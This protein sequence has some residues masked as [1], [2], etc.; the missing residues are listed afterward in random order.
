MEARGEGGASRTA[1]HRP[2]VTA[3]QVC[4]RGDDLF[5]PTCYPVSQLDASLCPMNNIWRRT[6]ALFC[7]HRKRALPHTHARTH[8]CTLANRMLRSPPPAQSTRFPATCPRLPRRVIRPVASCEINFLEFKYE[9]YQKRRLPFR[10][11]FVR[12]KI[13]LDSSLVRAY[14]ER[15]NVRFPSDSRFVD[16]GEIW[17]KF[18]SVIG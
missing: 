12:G 2:A 18:E 11:S 10:E 15:S 1:S 16:A 8:S 9:G 17:T 5:P 14:F 6:S 4:A 7:V 13:S 3:E